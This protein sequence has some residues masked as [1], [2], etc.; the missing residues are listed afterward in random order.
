MD[1]EENFKSSN[2][3]WKEI[4]SSERISLIRFFSVTYA[5]IVLPF[6]Q[7]TSVLIDFGKSFVLRFEN[8]VSY[9]PQYNL[10]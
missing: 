5:S 10:Y 2:R 3:S 9:Q 6:A 1:Q 8:E 4:A 7:R